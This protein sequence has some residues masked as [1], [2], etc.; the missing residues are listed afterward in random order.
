MFTNE[1]HTPKF[2]SYGF[3]NTV[4]NVYVIGI[5]QYTFSF[6]AIST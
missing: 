5:L 2:Q 6:L 3:I 4:F 1:T